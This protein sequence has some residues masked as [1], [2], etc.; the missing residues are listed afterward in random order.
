MDKGC[1]ISI[2]NCTYE[3]KEV[4]KATAGLNS[5][6]VGENSSDII[7]E[8]SEADVSDEEVDEHGV[9]SRDDSNH[10][11]AVQIKD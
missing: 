1:K 9:G 3:E 10:S 4:E 5:L 8:E 7:S 6:Q 11:H 2:L